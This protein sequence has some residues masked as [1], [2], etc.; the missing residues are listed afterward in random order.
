MHK[1][2]KACTGMVQYVQKWLST[3]CAGIVQYKYC[4]SMVQYVQVW[5][6]QYVH[7]WYIYRDGTVCEQMVQIEH[8]VLQMHK[9]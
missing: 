1:N 7:I 6:I 8:W 9:R 4:T 2:G 5:Y 3:V